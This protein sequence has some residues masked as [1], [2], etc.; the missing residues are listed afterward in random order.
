MKLTKIG[1]IIFFAFLPVALF[2]VII[3]INQ[4]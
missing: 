3:L 2:S 1:S 4:N